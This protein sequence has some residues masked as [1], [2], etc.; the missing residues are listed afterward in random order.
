M[1]IKQ[2]KCEQ[3]AGLQNRDIEFCDGLNILLGDNESGKSTIVDLIYCLF[4]QSERID[5]RSNKDFKNTYFT[6]PYGDMIDGKICFETE[7]GKYE[8]SK[9]WSGSDGRCKLIMPDGTRISGGDKIGE[10]LSL[11]LSYRKGIFDE[12]IFASQKRRQTMLRG[13]FQSKKAS[14]GVKE[15][16]SYT[17]M[18]AVMETGGINI[19]KM[20]KHLKELCAQYDEHW[21]FKMDLPQDG[22]KRGINNPWKLK[23]D[24]NSSIILRAYYAWQETAAEQSKARLAEERVESIVLKL[25]SAKRNKDESSKK[26]EEFL[27]FRDVLQQRKFLKRLSEENTKRLKEMKEIYAQWPEIKGR[28]ESAFE[29]QKRLKAA[30]IRDLFEVIHSYQ[31]DLRDKKKAIAE[32]GEIIREDVIKAKSLSDEIRVL[33]GK[34]A[35]LNLM[36]KIRRLGDTPIQVTAASD[37]RLLDISKD[38]LEI[39]EAIEIYIP[40]VL[41]LQLTPMG[42]DL[43]QIK[44]EIAD[45]RSLLQ[46][47]F[48]KY[49]INNLNKL[50]DKFEKN[51]DLLRE[52]SGLEDKIRI[53]LGDKKW[54]ELKAENN[55]VPKDG[56]S[57]SE[58]KKHIADLC[59]NSSVEVYIGKQSAKIEN[60]EKVYTS[61]EQLIRRISEME[62]EIENHK[63]EI[64]GFADIPEK[65]QNIDDPES[66]DKSLKSEIDSY[67]EEIETLNEELAEAKKDSGERSAEEYSEELCAKKAEFEQK[68]AEYGHWKHIYEVFLQLKN[69]FIG[70][71][72]SDIEENFREYLS[73]LSDGFISLKSINEEL[74]SQITSG[75]RLL[76]YEILSEGTK[77]TISLAFRLAILKHLYPKGGG[78]VVFDDPFTDM[79]AKRAARACSL[80]QKYSQ[81]NQ[82][83]FVT[84][85]EKYKDLMKGNVIEIKGV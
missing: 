40:E 49:K 74:S 9:E 17:I 64:D 41:E 65:Y 25:K 77:D 82:V 21:D 32:N 62:K 27:A 80:V 6:V 46:K 36:A 70:N 68:K 18:K 22:M 13:L 35:G 26:R 73:V 12:V 44:K 52:A 33:E 11:E 53:K 20:E 51:V 56:E 81:N 31:S 42:V 84:C 39:T 34:I 30:E 24:V 1:K 79:D 2:L 85:D 10:I 67:Y 75:N 14:G 66:Y 47:I 61:F 16:L 60:F 38:K 71:P 76:T 15:D 8:L 4:F 28:Y 72:M 55:A 23:K 57:V 45:K 48:D 43:E 54:E 59:G 78:L 5:G 29:L 58:I 7:R 37:G 50:C 19:D 69:D 83:I 3:F 63:K